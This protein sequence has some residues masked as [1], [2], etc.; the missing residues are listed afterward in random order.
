MS[1]PAPG[2]EFRFA[3]LIEPP[4]CYRAADGE[5]TGCDVEVARHVF[6][7]L[8]YTSFVS[9]ET[10]FADLLPGLEDGR[11]H[12]TT[13]MFVTP[14]RARRATFC[15][16]VWALPDGLL[17]A[18]GNPHGITG[19]GSLARE[20]ALRLGVVQDQMQHRTALDIGVPEARIRIFANYPE[21]AAAVAGG[22]VDAYASVAMAH[23]GHLA[24]HPASGLSIVEVPVSDKPAAVG[25]FAV[26]RAA[27]DLRDAIDAALAGFLGSSE[28]RALMARFGFSD[29]QVDLIA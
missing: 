18:G 16:P 13:G 5:V 14:E 2:E 27:N 8:G 26:P 25:A 19:Y 12:M 23:A 6:R 3:Y 21:A 17:V 1:R 15:R 11:W 10:E 7:T 4:F 20:P 22:V 24:E 28:H 9:V 29:A